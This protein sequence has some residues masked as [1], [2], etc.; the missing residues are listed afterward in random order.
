MLIFARSISNQITGVKHDSIPQVLFINIHIS[1]FNRDSNATY[2]LLIIIY[3]QEQSL[4][5]SCISKISM[6]DLTLEEI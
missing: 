5:G 2:N 1:V 4:T 6:N 3:D